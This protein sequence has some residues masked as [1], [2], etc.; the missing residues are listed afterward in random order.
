MEALQS[1]ELTLPL[2]LMVQ[3]I[4]R[5]QNPCHCGVP[6]ARQ[7]KGLQR[8]PVS[9]GTQR[10]PLGDWG[11]AQ[12]V[13]C[14]PPKCEE[15]ELTPLPQNSHK[16]SVWQKES[17]PSDGMGRD[18]GFLGARW[19]VRLAFWW[20]SRPARE[21]LISVAVIKISWLRVTG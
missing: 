4:S 7:A 18:R 5:P 16:N 15:P 1:P 13:T 21:P 6:L 20:S 3:Q 9:Q 10:A 14:L 12:S 8:P 2:E 11:V 17:H 19:P